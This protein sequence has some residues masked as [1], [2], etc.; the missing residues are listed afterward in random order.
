[1]TASTKTKPT[2]N[3]KRSHAVDAGR[4]LI[5]AL[6]V[7]MALLVLGFARSRVV[8]P[9]DNLVTEQMCLRHGEAIERT[10][11]DFERSNNFA[12]QDRSDGFCSYGPGPEGEPAVTMTVEETEPGALY[13]WAK[14][15]GIMLQ[16]G[17]ASIFVRLVT[18]PA[19]ETYNFLTQR[20]GRRPSS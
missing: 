11:L 2:S 5:V 18:E 10:L 20:L 14:A 15:V 8:A 13:T 1:M 19:L 4:W 7:I 3:E 17:I 16:L 12:L 9:F 6:I